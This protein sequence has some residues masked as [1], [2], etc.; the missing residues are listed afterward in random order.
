[1]AGA[2]YANSDR[3][4]EQKQDRRGDRA[5][6]WNAGFKYDASRVYLAAYYGA[7]NNMHYIGSADGFS[8][9]ARGFE[10]LAQYHFDSGFT[11]SVLYTQGTALNLHNDDY[12]HNMDY[13]KFFDLAGMYNFN[14]N[15]ELIVEYKLNLLNRNMFTVA[16]HISTDDITNVTLKYSF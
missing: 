15:L 5:T 14:K 1:S 16:N 3:T 10:V 7:V 9:K 12:S 6:G 4:L 2:S 11:P 8:H 13:I